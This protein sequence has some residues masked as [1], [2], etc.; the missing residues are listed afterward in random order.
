MIVVGAIGM[1]VGI[2]VT[3]RQLFLRQLRVARISPEEL[4]VKLSAGDPVYIVDLR[5][6][7]DVQLQPVMIRGAERID[8]AALEQGR[9]TIPRERETVLYCS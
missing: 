4:L 8:P 2:K 3:R 1:Y 6:D 7:L 5:H 9:V